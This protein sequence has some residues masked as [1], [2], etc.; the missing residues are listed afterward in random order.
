MTA[1]SKAGAA[2]KETYHERERYED[3]FA[4]ARSGAD[5]QQQ[6]VKAYLAWQ[7]YR[8]PFDAILTGALYRRAI[9]AFAIPPALTSAEAETP[10]TPDG[11]AAAGQE[12]KAVRDTIAQELASHAAQAESLWEDYVSV[13]GIYK[14]ASSA[15]VL[16]ACQASVRTL[17]GSGKMWGK[18]LM[19]LARF[20]RGETELAQTFQ[21]ALDAGQC[22]AATAPGGGADSLAHLLLGRCE[23][24]KELVL[25]A[26]ATV[27]KV[28]LE[29][30]DLQGDLESF[31]AVL[32][33]AETCIEMARNF[34]DP[35]L[36]LIRFLSGWCERGGD[37]TAVLASAHWDDA[38][39]AQQTNALVWIEATRYFARTGQVPKARQLYK[40][41]CG[42]QGIEGKEPLLDAWVAFERT[43]G[44]VADVE[45]AMRKTKEETERM[46][47][48]YYRSYAAQQSAAVAFAPA[49]SS[50][51]ATGPLAGSK[52]A[53][54]DESATASTSVLDAASKKGKM[55]QQAKFKSKDRENCSVLVAGLPPDSKE[56]DLRVLFRGCGEIVDISGPKPVVQDGT[57]AA[58]VEFADREAIP[59]AQTRDKKLVRGTEVAV[60]IGYTCTLYVTNF[61]EETTDADIRDRFGRYGGLFDVRWPSRKFASSR[62][63]CYVEMTSPAA[64]AEA[65]RVENGTKLSDLHTLTVA[66]SDPDR[67]KQ[68]TDANSYER[69]VYITGVAPDYDEEELRAL[70]D[71]HGTIVGLRVPRKADGSGGRGIAFVDYSTP[72][73]AQKAV[74]VVHG[75]T[76][77][78][79]QLRVQIAS[80]NKGT[81]KEAEAPVVRSH[82]IKLRG[83]P[84]DAQEALIQQAVEKVAGLGTVRKV[85]WTPGAESRGEALVEFSDP[86]VSPFHYRVVTAPS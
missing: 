30:V 74:T 57:A 3:A 9:A 20:G 40:Q 17:P 43:Y 41:V 48:A 25:R 61:P 35:Q 53:A 23:A 36:R 65:T 46:W 34:P 6:G 67:R 32:A 69:E 56:G 24:E 78:G 8:K 86:A 63:F 1:A 28:A 29:N 4:Q 83:L 5:G 44:S 7:V 72:L 45:Y 62:R 16:D 15:E 70:F 50:D 71:P 19:N 49:A 12:S 31:S 37:Q 79:K 2:A 66:L 10:L 80:K 76:Y 27:Q 47:A 81:N 75:T 58:V 38:L 33:Q 68:R 77:R 11:P 85:D 13:L 42:R 14:A 21:R 26:S 52:R 84:F 18:Y 82:S 64:A 39:A 73:E 22:T 60:H 55:Q 54:E 51:A 59:A